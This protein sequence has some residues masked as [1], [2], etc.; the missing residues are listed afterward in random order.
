[1]GKTV[2][3]VRYDIPFLDTGIIY[4]DN[5]ATTPTPEPVINAMLEYFHEYSANIGRGLHQTAKRATEEFESSRE[6]IARTIGAKPNEIAY[7]KNTT[8]GLNLL[9]K[10]L[11]LNQG[12]KVI[13]TVLEHHSNLIPWQRLE[14]KEGI[15]LEVIE[16]TPDA[17]T[18]PSAIEQAAD[19]DTSLITMSSVSNSFGTKQPIME[20]AE[21]AKDKDALFLV[22]AAQG[23]GHMPIDVEEIGCDFLVAPGHKGLLG[24]QGTGF[25]YIREDHL[26]EVEP[27]LYG[28]GIVRSV[29]EHE[30][31]LV[32]PPNIFDAGTPNIPGIIG[33]GEG[34][35]YVLDIGLEKIE[36][37]ETKLV[38]RMLKIQEIEGVEIYGPKSAEDLGGVVSFNVNGINHHEVSS[39]LDEL[40]KIATR[41]GNHCAQPAMS[42]FGLEG[43]VRASVHYYNKEKNIDR[44]VETLE[45]IVEKLAE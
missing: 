22:D 11:G 38:E 2:K 30:H 41:S 16:D 7:T 42:H 43:N 32:N 34:A 14:E 40:E 17:V 35:N 24:P 6:K 28:G 10:G 12:D 33:L 21:I 19:E 9:S 4:L 25:M 3:E 29:E 36:K 37:R 13:T 1:M 31:E 39:L 23:V 15:N 18:N 44:F 27:L 26:N 45:D 5:A 20:V 8:E